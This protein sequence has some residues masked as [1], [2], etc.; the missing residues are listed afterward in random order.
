[1]FT[2]SYQDSRTEFKAGAANR[3]ESQPQLYRL[4]LK[5]Q[6]A[7][8]LTSCYDTHRLPLHKK[9][10]HQR[11]NSL[12]ALDVFLIDGLDF[13]VVGGPEEIILP[14]LQEHVVTVVLLNPL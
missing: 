7:A 14:L 8:Q 3:L 11:P 2:L 13:W 1:M 9:I 6:H 5:N 4:L 12:R 10:T